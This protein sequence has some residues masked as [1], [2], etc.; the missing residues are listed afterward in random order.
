MMSDAKCAE[1]KGRGC[2]VAD[3][4]SGGVDGGTRPLSGLSGP[5]R[6]CYDRFPT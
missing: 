4:Q 5:T 6:T 2:S 3:R 1:Q